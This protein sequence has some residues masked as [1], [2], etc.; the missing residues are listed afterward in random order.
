MLFPLPKA[1]SLFLSLKRFPW[2]L[3]LTTDGLVV[4]ADVLT[5][6]GYFGCFYLLLESL[7]IRIIN[8]ILLLI[9]HFQ[10]TQQTEAKQR[11][12]GYSF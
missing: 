2:L 12:D 1:I 6:L 7:L 5:F 8:I 11:D 3:S 9:L 10:T 4:I